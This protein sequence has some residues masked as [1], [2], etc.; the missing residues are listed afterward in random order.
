M[1]WV[2]IRFL[3]SILLIR[4]SNNSAKLCS[5]TSA[6]TAKRGTS[7]GNAATAHLIRVDN[8]MAGLHLLQQFKRCCIWSQLNWFFLCLINQLQGPRTRSPSL[9]PLLTV[10]IGYFIFYRF[11]YLIGLIGSNHGKILW[12]DVRI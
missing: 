4:W 11:S 7:W 10:I 12:G 9:L 5:L 6:V 1:V 3:A 2:C 8:G